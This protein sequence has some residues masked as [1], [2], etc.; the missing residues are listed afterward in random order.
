[1]S[2]TGQDSENV[3]R[4]GTSIGDIASS[5]FCVIGILSQLIFRNKTDLGS[6]LDLSMLDCQVAILENAIARFS[7][8]NVN[9]IPLGTDHPSIAPFGAFQTKD[10]KIVIAIGNEKL[11][12]EFCVLIDDLKMH[13]DKK[14]N[15]NL[16]RCINLKELKERI[17]QKLSKKKLKK[18]D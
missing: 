1:M 15:S 6:K 8:D 12:K 5:L 10:E 4:V 16:N 2:L 9:P 11:F 13:K 7:I 18:L 17:E 14:Y 3:V